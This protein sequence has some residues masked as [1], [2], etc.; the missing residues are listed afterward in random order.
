MAPTG[1]SIT[2]RFT[3]P[4]LAAGALA[5]SAPTATLAA[6]SDSAARAALATERYL[7]SYGTPHPPVPAA[8]QV[9]PSNGPTWIAAIL[10]GIGLAIG[11]G[12]AGIAGGRATAHPKRVSA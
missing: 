9:A 10:A 11:A 2:S 5:I 8:A 6:T 4:L 12:I 3:L 1:R 7:S